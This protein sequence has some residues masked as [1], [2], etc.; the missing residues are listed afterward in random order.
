[1]SNEPLIPMTHLVCGK[2]A[3]FVTRKPKA[4][5][6]IDLSI[7]RLLDGTAPTPATPMVCGACGERAPGLWQFQPAGGFE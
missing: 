6:P 7:I 3:F 2:T 5:E 1:V 4:A